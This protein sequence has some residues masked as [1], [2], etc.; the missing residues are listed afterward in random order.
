MAVG[1]L[2][3][4]ESP[5]HGEP[6]RLGRPS[7]GPRSGAAAHGATGPVGGGR[8]YSVR[9]RSDHSTR[10]TKMVGLPNLAFQF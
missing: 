10:E 7:T 9:I 3:L 1:H 2:C 4:S 6:R 8:G 5:W